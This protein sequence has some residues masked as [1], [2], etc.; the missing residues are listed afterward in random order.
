M[1]KSS[2]IL[3]IIVISTLSCTFSKK[4]LKVSENSTLE[5][6]DIQKVGDEGLILLQQK[7]YACHSVT[8]KSHDE[9]IAPPLIAIVRRYKMSYTTKEEFIAAVSNWALDPF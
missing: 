9:I 8:S 7:C 4:E 5:D 1:I 3:V 2:L 6:V